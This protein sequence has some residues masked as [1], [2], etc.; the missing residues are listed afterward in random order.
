[1]HTKLVPT[2]KVQHEEPED[3]EDEMEKAFYK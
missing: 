2:Q 3:I 1:M